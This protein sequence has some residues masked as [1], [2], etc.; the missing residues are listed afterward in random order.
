MWFA[1]CLSIISQQFMRLILMIQDKTFVFTLSL[2]SISGSISNVS[3][4]KM[5]WIHVDSRCNSVPIS[6][7][8][9]KQERYSTRH[10]ICT[11]RLP[12]T[13]NM[14]W[15]A[16]AIQ[17]VTQ[18]LFFVLT[19]SFRFCFCFQGIRKHRVAGKWNHAR[20]VIRLWPN[21]THRAA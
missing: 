12:E 4:A 3:A 7:V 16:R 13:V 11:T 18:F 8:Q 17:G 2:L 14:I 19:T 20:S 21:R 1:T 6:G 10:F 9:G 15:R 5:S